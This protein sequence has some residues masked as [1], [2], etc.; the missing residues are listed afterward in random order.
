MGGLF[1]SGPSRSDIRKAEEKAMEN[2]RERLRI[3]EQKMRRRESEET[4]Q[5]SGLATATDMTLGDDIAEMATGLEQVTANP[6]AQKA[7]YQGKYS[8]DYQEKVARGKA[9]M[10]IGDKGKPGSRF[11]PARS[12]D[13]GIYF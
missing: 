9:G 3:Q 10:W 13:T 8:K 2:E 12:T 5:G 6:V 11:S 7:S 4:M 1:S